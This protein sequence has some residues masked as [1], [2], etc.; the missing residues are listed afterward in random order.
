MPSTRESFV[1]VKMSWPPVRT[2]PEG[3]PAETSQAINGCPVDEKPDCQDN[4][5]WAE[6]SNAGWLH[7]V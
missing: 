6:G 3:G 7:P 2:G 4:A 1:R 5:L